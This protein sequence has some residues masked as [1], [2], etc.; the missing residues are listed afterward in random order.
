MRSIVKGRGGV[1]TGIESFTWEY[2]IHVLLKFFQIFFYKSHQGSI[3]VIYIQASSFS[4]HSSFVHDW[5]FQIVKF[6]NEN[7]S[8][9]QFFSRTTWH[10]GHNRGFNF[11]VRMYTIIHWKIFLRR[12]AIPN[13]ISIDIQTSSCSVDSSSSTPGKPWSLQTGLIRTW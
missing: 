7:F 4:I 8:Q 13:N 11:C 6:Q 1:T 3:C 12:N 9:E 5:R 10:I 2:V